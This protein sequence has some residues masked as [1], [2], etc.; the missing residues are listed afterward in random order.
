MNPVK[1]VV[2]TSCLTVFWVSFISFKGGLLEEEKGICDD[3]SSFASAFVCDY[4]ESIAVGEI[5][6]RVV[7]WTFPSSVVV[8]ATPEWMWI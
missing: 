1:S 3:P 7:L 4:S 5:Y 2:G 6:F 8:S